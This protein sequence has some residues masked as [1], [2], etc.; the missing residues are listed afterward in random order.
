[1]SPV[2]TYIVLNLSTG[3]LEFSRET[4][5]SAVQCVVQMRERRPEAAYMIAKIE[6]VIGVAPAPQ[7]APE[8][9]RVD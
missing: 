3:A 4:L 1:M 9:R 5:Q 6:A 8:R 2:G 7:R